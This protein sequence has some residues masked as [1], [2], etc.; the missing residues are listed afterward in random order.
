MEIQAKE[1]KVNAS[2]DISLGELTRTF[3]RFLEQYTQ[4]MQALRTDLRNMKIVSPDLYQANREAD[5]IRIEKLEKEVENGDDRISTLTR[6][7]V[8]S[9]LGA[10]T[11]IIVAV[12]QAGL[13]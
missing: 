8:L 1:Q 10:L 4:D 11:A 9:L 3:S 2:E 13:H 7:M 5:R 6:G 12:V